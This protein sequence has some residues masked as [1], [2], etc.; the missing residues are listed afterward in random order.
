MIY[1]SDWGKNPT[2]FHCLYDGSRLRDLSEQ[3]SK[4]GFQSDARLC[5][6]TYVLKASSESIGKLKASVGNLLKDFQKS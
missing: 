6:K 3:L 1:F 2:I 5:Y 4:A